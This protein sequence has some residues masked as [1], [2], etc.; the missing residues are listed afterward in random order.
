MPEG[1]RIQLDP[2]FD[3]NTLKDRTA[4]IVAKALQEYG[5]YV[6]DYAGNRGKIYA[7]YEG[8]ANW[9]ADSASTRFWSSKVV[10]SIPAGKLRVLQQSDGR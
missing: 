4:R 7:E 2:S 3:V 6:V 8:T 1:A 5:A 9:S 10:S